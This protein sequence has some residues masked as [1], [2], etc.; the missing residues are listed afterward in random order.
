MPIAF[1]KTPRSQLTT[2]LFGALSFCGSLLALGSA[3]DA[4]GQGPAP[5]PAPPAPARKTNI[6]LNEI[7]EDYKFFADDVP[8]FNFS[9]R[10]NFYTRITDNTVE[11]VDFTTG[12]PSDVLFDYIAAGGNANGLPERFDDYVFSADGGKALIAT[13]SEAIYRRSSRANYYLF[14]GDT[15]RLTALDTAGAQMYATFSPDGSR[16]A[17]VRA[18]DLYVK[19]LASGEVTRVTDDGEANAIINGA[20]DWVYEEEF[21]I[22][23]AF[24]WS[25]SGEELLFLRF[26]ERLVPEYTMEKYTDELYPEYVTFKYPK[27]GEPNSTVSARV[28]TLA[29]GATRI[30]FDTEDGDT[31]IPRLYW[32]PGNL[33]VLLTTNRHQDTF[34]LRAEPTAGAELNV[35]HRETSSRYLEVNDDL[36]FLQDGSFL[37]SGEG[38]GFN[39]LYHYDASGELIR[40]LTGGNYPVTEFYGYDPVSETLFFQAARESPMRRE[41]YNVPLAGGTPK[42]MSSESGWNDAQFNADFSGYMLAHSTANRPP[43]YAVYERDGSLLRSLVDNASVVATQGEEGVRE[44]EFFSFDT[45]EGIEL[46]GWRITPEGFSE[47]GDKVYPLFMFVYGGPGSQQVVDAWSGVN[48]W[49]FQMLAQQGYVVACVDNRGTGGRGV[50]F[51]KQTFLKLGDLEVKDQIAAA[52]HLGAQPYIDAERIGIFGWSYGGYMTSLCITKGAGVFSLAIAVAPVTN[53]KWYDTLYTERYM[54]TTEENPAGYRENS[55]VYFADR[56]EGDYLL[57]HG[58]GDDNV[59]FQHSVEMVDA[60]VAANKE[61][62]FFAYP[63]RNHGIYGGTTRLHLYELMTEFI[64]ERL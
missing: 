13:G 41:V 37:L 63:N 45:E 16:V 31:H 33:P 47:S 57:V 7:W 12:E 25:P 21:S 11:L 54:H 8:G 53:W 46:N 2:A 10:G 22:A 55:P 59:H 39:H 56:L 23:Q 30:I 29:S 34:S 20:T 64:N 35:L 15:A 32:T 62:E 60:L 18:N 58:M 44:V 24:A 49:W 28:Y 19:E 4:Y 50:E 38:T 9:D 14:T 17:Y 42:R 27:V 3:G 51:E 36:R 48:Y 61:F 40:Q 26:D 52:K 1:A 5:V 6:T 43:T